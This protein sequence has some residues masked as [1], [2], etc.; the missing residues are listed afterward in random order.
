MTRD[1]II[2]E[3]VKYVKQELTGMEAGHDW[4]HIE[5]VWKNAKTIQKHE[6]KA[7][8]LVVSL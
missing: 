7:N 2:D 6:K 3:T 8:G 5:R 1:T 4:Y